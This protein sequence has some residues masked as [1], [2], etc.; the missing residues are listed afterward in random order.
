MSDLMGHLRATEG[1]IERLTAENKRLEG[2]LHRVANHERHLYEA[3][4][5]AHDATRRVNDGFIC[6]PFVELS[7]WYTWDEEI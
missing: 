1:E 2:I 4:E 7:D 6:G 5:K 3:A